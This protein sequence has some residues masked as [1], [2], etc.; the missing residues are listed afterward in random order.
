MIN[1]KELGN[2]NKIE[3]IE[4]Y[5]TVFSLNLL[6]F[7]DLDEKIDIPQEVIDIAE[8]RLLVRKNKDFKESDRLRDLIHEKGF[9]IKDL[10]DAYEITLL[11]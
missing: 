1:S 8:E 3:L 10:K 9:E 6:D 4:K 11:K 2:K 5:D 7:S